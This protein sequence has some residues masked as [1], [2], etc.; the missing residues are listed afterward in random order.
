[1]KL[2][3]VKRLAQGFLYSVMKDFCRGLTVENDART[4]VEPPLSFGDLAFSDEIKFDAFGEV[5]L[6]KA[7]VNFDRVL[8][9]WAMGTAKVNDDFSG[10]GEGGV[11]SHLKSVVVDES[12]AQMGR[13]SL[14]GLNESPGGANGV[15][16]QA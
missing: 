3:G 6:D 12:L 1:M 14:K 7:V 9:P 15:L 4:V 5:F 10:Y 11:L 16:S 8:L 13:Q 2:G